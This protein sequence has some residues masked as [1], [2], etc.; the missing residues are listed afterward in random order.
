MDRWIIGR[1]N[2]AIKNI[3]SALDAYNCVD[4]CGEVVTLVD[5]ISTW[6]IRRSRDRFKSDDAGP[7]EQAVR[8]LGY[9]LMNLSCLI[10]PMMPFMAED[11]YQ[12]LRRARND[13]PESVHLVDW[14]NYDESL[15]DTFVLDSMQTAKELVKMGL[16]IRAK[17]MIPVRQVLSD[18]VITGANLEPAFLEIVKEELNVKNISL[19]DGE[20]LS[21][22]MN[23]E[24]SPELKMEG[25][26]RDLIRHLN[27]CRKRMKL[28]YGQRIDLYIE[29]M[30]PEINEC[31]AQFGDKI[32]SSVQAD[33]IVEKIDDD[34][35]YEEITMHGIMIKVVLVLK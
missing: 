17:N 32:K 11:I 25:T 29:S 30:D 26:C 3:T 35:Q 15:V 21:L 19:L 28:T 1:L 10:A 16:E 18:L 8:T 5:D 6:Y 22:E 12:Q 33:M 9:V 7:R 20:S 31:L 4:A 2:V 14:P 23:T 13:L 24:L 34:Q 27:N